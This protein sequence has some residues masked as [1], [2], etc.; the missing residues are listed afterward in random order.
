LIWVRE[1]GTEG[2]WVVVVHGGPG[3]MGSMAVVARAL[4]HRFRVLEPWQRCSGGEPLTVARHIADMHEMVRA[5]CPDQ[6]PAL[7]GHSWGAMLALAYAAAHPEEAGPLVLAGCG[8]FDPAARM[9]MKVIRG[10][11]MNEA[12]IAQMARIEQAIVD[13]DERL[14]A[15]GR[16][17]MI[18]DS[19]D[20]A[21]T[22]TGLEACD[23]AANRETWDDMLHLQ[24]VGVYPAAFSA[25]R[26]PVLMVHGADDP[27]PGEMIRASLAPYLPQLEYHEWAR[28]GH[29][30]WLERGVGAEF[31]TVVSE[32]LALHLPTSD[33]L[34]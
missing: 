12:V 10:A 16:L 34:P 22:E 28:C 1:Y 26:T 25:I 8:T 19:Y 30:P 7:V 24:E 11:R 23:A 3:A 4:A 33:S 31:F 27:H 20:L 9:R 14:C 5:H 2:L 6:K 29:Y 15:L 13:P 21:S 17:F 18:L 32:W